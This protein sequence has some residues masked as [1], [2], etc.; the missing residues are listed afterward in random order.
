MDSPIMEFFITGN[1]I[2]MDFFVIHQL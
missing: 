1:I 2:I